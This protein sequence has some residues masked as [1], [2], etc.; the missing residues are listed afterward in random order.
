MTTSNLEMEPGSSD[1]MEDLNTTTKNDILPLGEVATT[2]NLHYRADQCPWIQG[3]GE[4][5][6]ASLS[7]NRVIVARCLEPDLVRCLCEASAPSPEADPVEE[8]RNDGE[9]LVEPATLCALV[10]SLASQ[11]HRTLTRTPCAQREEFD[12]LCQQLAD[13]QRHIERL[14]RAHAMRFDELNHWLESLMK[15]M[16]DRQFDASA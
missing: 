15:R 9:S 4:D 7:T 1:D 3:S 13:V 5:Q 14:R 2:R 6:M 11:A 8:D 10:R 16:Q 12:E